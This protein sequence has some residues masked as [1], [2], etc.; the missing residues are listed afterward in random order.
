MLLTSNKHNKSV[1]KKPILDL[2]LSAEKKL[3]PL[4]VKSVYLR[5][6]FNCFLLSLKNS[7]AFLF[8]KKNGF[9]RCDGREK[10]DNNCEKYSE[11]S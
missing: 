5:S 8:L 7:L 1:H 10:R 4:Y 9:S 3:I 2:N 6:V 11:Q